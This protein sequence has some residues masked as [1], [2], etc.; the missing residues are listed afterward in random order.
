MKKGEAGAGI[1]SDKW[2]YNGKKSEWARLKNN[3]QEV[4]V[5]SRIDYILNQAELTRMLTAPD[6]IT[7]ILVPDDETANEKAQR[8]L[9]QKMLLAEFEDEAKVH[10]ANRRAYTKDLKLAEQLLLQCVS[11]DIKIELQQYIASPVYKAIPNAKDAYEALWTRLHIT[12]GPYYSTL[13]YDFMLFFKSFVL[14]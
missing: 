13:V 1:V 4:L 7:A 2:K 6:P 9:E 14:N 8:E 10:R 11:L 5:N 12:H 3:Y